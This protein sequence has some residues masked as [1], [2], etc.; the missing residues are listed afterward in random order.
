M[1]LSFV[2]FVF[3]HCPLDFVSSIHFLVRPKSKQEECIED[4]PSS[5]RSFELCR[6]FVSLHTNIISEPAK[7][8]ETLP[9]HAQTKP[10]ARDPQS[11]YE[12]ACDSQLIRHKS[13]ISSPERATHL[14]YSTRDRH[15]RGVNARQLRFGPALPVRE[16]AR[17]VGQN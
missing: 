15:R 5:L 6:S 11:N 12:N 13:L 1:Y 4:D 17:R 7:D 16:G 8:S 2:V 3:I 10:A 14:D 9:K